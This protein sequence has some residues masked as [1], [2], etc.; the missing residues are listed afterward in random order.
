MRPTITW[1]LVLLVGSMLV[2]T[3][4]AE[5]AAMNMP[6]CAQH[7]ST[8]CHET[9][10]AP[11]GNITNGTVPQVSADIQ[12]VATAVPPVLTPPLSSHSIRYEFA[13]TSDNLL[14]CIH[15]LLL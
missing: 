5:C 7:H 4:F 10:A 8:T 6:C 1:L 11:S 9:C 14:T 13:P 12:A 2:G 15:V 3:A